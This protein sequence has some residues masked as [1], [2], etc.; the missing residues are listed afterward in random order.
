VR[1][2]DYQER[3]GTVRRET[4]PA[5]VPLILNYS[6]TLTVAGAGTGAGAFGAGFVAGPEDRFADT[7]SG[8][9]GRGVQVD[10]TW[11]EARQILGLPLAEV[12]RRNVT[13]EE[14]WGPAGRRLIERLGATAEP[15]QR[16][17]AVADFLRRRHRPD[18]APAVVCGA[19]GLL[20]QYRGGITVTDLAARLG[21]GRQHLHREVAHHLGLPPRTLARLLRFRAAAEAIRRG[22]ALADVAAGTGFYDQ[23]HLAREFRALAGTSPSAYAT[24]VQATPPPPG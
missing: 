12:A 14:L 9:D 16:M 3:P 10:L 7:H 8:G 18:A 17:A 5:G 23:A 6:G 22:T 20:A 1:L 21:V 2:T 19:A 13:V 24:N 15:M 4:A 11:L